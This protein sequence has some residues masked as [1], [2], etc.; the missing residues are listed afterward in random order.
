MIR[1]S[2]I[3]FLIWRWW[4]RRRRQP[5][6]LRRI[7]IISILFPCLIIVLI[8]QIAPNPYDPQY[9]KKSIDQDVEWSR[10]DEVIQAKEIV[11]F[12]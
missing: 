1:S 6:R 12:Y 4:R 2:S 5:I 8:I 7:S 10:I 11:G 3:S 9:E